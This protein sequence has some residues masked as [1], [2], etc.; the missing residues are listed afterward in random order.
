VSRAKRP[1]QLITGYFVDDCSQSF[2]CTGIDNQ[3]RTT[4]IQNAEKEKK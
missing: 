4:K 3:T 2:T 1:R